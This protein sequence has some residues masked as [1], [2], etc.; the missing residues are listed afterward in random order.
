MSKLKYYRE[1]AGMS[2]SELASILDVSQRYIAFLE[3]GERTP[4]LYLAQ[5][6]ANYF[7]VSIEDIFL[8]TKRTKSTQNIN[9]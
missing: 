7:K 6:I 4:S 9:N 3:T 5:K 2:Q 1:K 8:P